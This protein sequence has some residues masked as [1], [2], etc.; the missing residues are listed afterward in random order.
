MILRRNREH[1]NGYANN[2]PDVLLQMQFGQELAKRYEREHIAIELRAADVEAREAR[3]DELHAR[4][5]ELERAL[6]AAVAEQRQRELIEAPKAPDE[7]V[8]LDPRLIV[9]HPK[10]KRLGKQLVKRRVVTKSAVRDA[11]K[12][13]EQ[14]GGRIGEI[15]IA[16]G[17]LLPQRLLEELAAQHGVAIVEPDDRGV[18]LIPANVALEQRAVALSVGKR[19][20]APGALTAVAFVDLE[21]APM[22]AEVLRG[23]IEPRLADAETIARLFADAYSSHRDEPELPRPRVTEFFTPVAPPRPDEHQPSTNG[24]HGA[25][26]GT[27]PDPRPTAAVPEVSVVAPEPEAVAVPEPDSAA[28]VP[29]SAPQRDAEAPEAAASVP[30][31]SEPDAEPVASEPASVVAESSGH[32]AVEPE[33]EDAVAAPDLP[34]A[35][36]VPLTPA[37]R[38]S[39]L[40]R[41]R[42][43]PAVATARRSAAPLEVA[44]PSP[45]PETKPAEPD[46]AASAPVSALPTMTIVVALRRATSVAVVPLASAL[47]RLDYPRHRLQ[48]MAVYDPADEMTRRTLL[49]IPLPGWVAEVPLPHPSTDDPR[50]LLLSGVREASGERIV[51]IQ[52]AR[53]LEGISLSAV[54]LGEG[55]NRLVTLDSTDEQGEQKLADAYLRQAETMHRDVLGKN[56]SGRIPDLAVFQTAE[57]ARALGTTPANAG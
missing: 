13:Q 25:H 14:N 16:S 26:N 30:V 50:D 23:A 43:R 29:D 24:G 17:V 44:S 7:Q 39:W 36:P 2:D 11:L 10:G 37:P 18:G 27:A 38:R 40:G 21:S 41:R 47:E 12:T 51:V 49:G 3:I 57:L 8:A 20:V 28:T 52:S 32:V 6:A 22:I 9:G 42:R 4:V 34:A 31:V 54:V 1:V 46:V 19:S 56:G 55:R 5:R 35:R 33:P 53:Q 45:A 15:L 48:A